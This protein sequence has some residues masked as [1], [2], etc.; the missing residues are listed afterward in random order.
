MIFTRD[1][2]LVK[3]VKTRGVHFGAKEWAAQFLENKKKAIKK[4]EIQAENKIKGIKTP[5]EAATYR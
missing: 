2:L 3:S 1:D 4:S 5:R